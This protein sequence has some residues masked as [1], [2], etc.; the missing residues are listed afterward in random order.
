MN[1]YIPIIMCTWKRIERLPRTIKLLQSQTISNKIHFYIWN[2]NSSIS[3]EI[4][5]I[6]SNYSDWVAVSHS[7]TNVGGI[8]RFMYAKQLTNEYDKC[9]FIDDDQIFNSNFVETLVSNYDKHTI[10]GWYGFNFINDL[11]WSK[12][13]QT[14]HNGECHYVGTGGMIVDI[15]IFDND[16]VF[17]CPN[18]F[19]FVED[20]WLSYVA[21]GILHWKLYKLDVY[22]DMVNDNKNQYTK[23][24]NTK[25][26][27]MKY[28]IHTLNWNLGY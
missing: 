15:S 7:D 25:N 24:K 20:L 12:Q 6:V 21:H 26:D 19:Q 27:M 8:G 18:Q 2:N 3:S 14:I 10:K 1:D 16:I 5:S 17:G 4:D 23:L 28:L 13:P 9:I 11:Y 22:M